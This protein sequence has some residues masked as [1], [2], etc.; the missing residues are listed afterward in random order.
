VSST[1]AFLKKKKPQD[2]ADKEIKKVRDTILRALNPEILILFGSYAR[3]E[4]T[5]QSDIDILIV[6][7]D[8]SEIS[9]ARK[10]LAKVRPINDV[11]LDVIWMSSED[12]HAKKSVGG[13]AMVASEEGY[14]LYGDHCDKRT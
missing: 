3:G 4:M 9:S 12:F 6:M 5:D 14:Q 7:S 11:P 2:E 8:P 13:V 1:L 10:S